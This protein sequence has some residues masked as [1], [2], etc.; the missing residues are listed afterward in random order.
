MVG[1]G[2]SRAGCLMAAACGA[3]VLL[4]DVGGVAQAAHKRAR[5]A[6]ASAASKPDFKEMAKRMNANTLT[7]VTGTPNLA[8]AAFGHDLAAVL[9]GGDEVWVLPVTS[10]G[11]AE[12]VRDVRFLKSIDLG[13]AQTNILGHYRRSGEIGDLTD[14]LVY[15]AKICNEEFHVIARSDIVSLEQLRGKKVNLNTAGSGTQIAARDIFA[16]LGIAVDEVDVGPTEGLEKLKNGE[17]A[18]TVIAAAKPAPAL[19]ALRASDG[20]GFVPVPFAHALQ[21]DFLPTVLSHDDYPSL[22]TRGTSIDTIATSTVLL[23]YNWPKD[24]DRYRRIDRFVKAFFSKLA[25]FQRPPR[26]AKWRET[27]LAASIPGWKRFEG[28]QAWLAANRGET[29]SVQRKLF[30][31]FLAD[32]HVPSLNGQDL[33]DRDRNQLF[34]EFIKWSQARESR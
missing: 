24:S 23:A 12:N 11:A 34:E 17:I 10:Q 27:N 30:E 1:S 15:I 31:R 20:Y 4:G 32:Q 29:L 3:L 18:A 13:F 6:Q 26:H 7:L 19:A 22:I 28:A 16:R 5:A 9:N 33:S 14:R 21:D 8:Y 25:E 2:Q